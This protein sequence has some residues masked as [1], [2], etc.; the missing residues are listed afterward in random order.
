MYRYN[1]FDANRDAVKDF[2]EFG[3]NRID[4]AKES[5]I[6]NRKKAFYE[7]TIDP[8]DSLY[9]D[10]EATR[11]AAVSEIAAIDEK[12]TA[13]KAKKFEYKDE[14]KTLYKDYKSAT[15]YAQFVEALDVWCATKGFVDD[16][17]GNRLSMVIAEAMGWNEIHANGSRAMLKN[18]NKAQAGKDTA[19]FTHNKR[20][21]GDFLRTLYGFVCD[22]CL[23]KTIKAKDF[24]LIS[25][26]TLYACYPNL[27]KGAKKATKKAE[28]K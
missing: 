21:Q 24:P 3:Y 17:Q 2:V 15:T 8:N 7:A 16:K 18:T 5:A 20:T 11:A 10:N 27:K 26:E 25:D 19:I 22:Y 6:L 1:V 12:L 9:S 23:G 28:N 13:L 4:L 14:D